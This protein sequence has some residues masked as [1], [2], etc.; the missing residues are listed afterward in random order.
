[1]VGLERNHLIG[2]ASAWPNTKFRSLLTTAVPFE[3]IDCPEMAS[4]GQQKKWCVPSGQRQ[5]THFCSDS[6]ETLGT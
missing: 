5:A 1:M 3:A 2:V 4:I 6:Q